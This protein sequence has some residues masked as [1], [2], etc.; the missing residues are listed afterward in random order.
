MKAKLNAP[1]ERYVLLE[2]YSKVTQEEVMRGFYMGEHMETRTE[3]QT[4]YDVLGEYA[5]LSELKENLEK[6]L[7]SANRRVDSEIS[8]LKKLR[9]VHTVAITDTD[10]DFI[11]T[12]NQEGRKI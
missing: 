1:S 4:C 5:T 6:V 12:S 9:F 3:K 10:S 8:A 2:K 7:T 11:A